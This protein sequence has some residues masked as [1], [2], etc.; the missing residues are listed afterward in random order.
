MKLIIS[1]LFLNFSFY[2]FSHE[3]FY[4]FL[5][6][7]TSKFKWSDYELKNQENFKQ[8]FIKMYH[9]DFEYYFPK[10]RDAYSG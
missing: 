9:D 1:I 7:D 5:N 3:Y 4:S 8:A 10:E 6:T 2:S